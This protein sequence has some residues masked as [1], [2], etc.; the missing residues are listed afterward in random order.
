M[1]PFAGSAKTAGIKGWAPI[2]ANFIPEYSVASHWQ[3]YLEGCAE[4]KREPTTEWRV[5]RNI[6]VAPSDEEARAI[7][8]DPKGSFYHYYD[9]L[10]YGLS[11]SK[12]TQAIKP[13][14]KIADG[15]VT[16]PYLID[17]LVIYGS[18]KTVV[19]KLL[20]FRERV[21]PFGKLILATIDWSGKYRDYD[22]RSMDLLAREVMPA[23]GKA[24]GQ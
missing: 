6:L 23:F 9:Y 5:C 17:Q 11:V 10:W 3:K 24:I 16:V 12:Y 1:S 18:P 8:H 21:G 13:D 2:S 22:S 14:P 19:E 15:D 4:A 20:G 7:A